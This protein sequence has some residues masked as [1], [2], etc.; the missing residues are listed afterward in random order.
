MSLKNRR[1]AEKKIMKY[2][3]QP[4]YLGSNKPGRS[5]TTMKD[6]IVKI[7]EEA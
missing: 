2:S 7:E 3:E 5:I 1:Q 6:K 4:R